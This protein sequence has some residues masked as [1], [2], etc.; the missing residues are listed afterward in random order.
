[1]SEAT[2]EITRRWL[3]TYPDRPCDIAHSQATATYLLG[4]G[5]THAIAQTI[6]DTPTAT[7]SG[8]QRRQETYGE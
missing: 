1:M 7:L 4:H 3:V 5:G 2:D 8:Y 6:S